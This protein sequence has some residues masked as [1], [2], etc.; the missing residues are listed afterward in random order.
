[1]RVIHK[2]K[3]LS[4]HKQEN[5]LKT[6]LMLFLIALIYVVALPFLIPKIFKGISLRFKFHKVAVTRGKFIIFVYSNSPNWKSYIE[7]NI[8]PQ[9]QDHAILLNWSDRGQW[10]K[11]EWAVQ[12]FHHW[13]GQE[14]F[15]PLAI[16]FCNL[17]DVRIIRFYSAFHDFKHGKVIPLQKAEAQ[18]LDLVMAKT[19]LKAG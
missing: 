5:P 9:I 8:L 14:N 10:K 19:H 16:V 15:N 13:G 6:G 4:G 1:M 17:V 3:D 7:A 12:A 18:L 11:T 2:V